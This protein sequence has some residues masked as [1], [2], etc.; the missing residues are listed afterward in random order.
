VPFLQKIG[1]GIPLNIRLEIFE[2][3]AQINSPGITIQKDIL[4]DAWLILKVKLA[5]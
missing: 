5:S 3:W 1:L 2:R 4:Q